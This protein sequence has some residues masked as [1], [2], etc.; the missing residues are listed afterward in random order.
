MSKEYKLIWLSG[1]LF[2]ARNVR[3]ALHIPIKQKRLGGV[4]NLLIYMQP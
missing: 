3:P 2:V 1:I 4:L